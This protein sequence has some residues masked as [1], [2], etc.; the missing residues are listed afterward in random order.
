MPAEKPQFREIFDANARYV[1]RA[2]RH[3]GVR[4]ADLLDVCQE[5]FIVAHRRLED[6]EGRSE[7]RTW[8]YGIAIRTV[9]DYRRRAHI[10]REVAVAEVPE[11][12]TEADQE[13][14]IER[15]EARALLLRLLDELDDDKRTVF[16]LYEIEQLPMKRVA[17]LV[18]CPLQ[19]AYSRLHA[20]RKAID[21][22]A[23][24]LPGRNP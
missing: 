2:V 13:R 23:R 9:S 8:L 10:R 11:G 6:F 24:E 3:L 19:T 21:K 12:A 22:A 4:E 16:V 14:N 20:A 15:A 1:W 5:V 7:I 17:D 18:A